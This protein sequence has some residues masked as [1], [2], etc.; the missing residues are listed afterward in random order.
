MN[1]TNMS[2]RDI[3]I[4]LKCI[5]V[6]ANSIKAMLTWALNVIRISNVESPTFSPLFI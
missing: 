1:V 3:L 6:V 2:W 4:N 5:L